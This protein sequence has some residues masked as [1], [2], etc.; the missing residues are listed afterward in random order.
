MYEPWNEK[1]DTV[2]FREYCPLLKLF[3]DES[4]ILT[5]TEATEQQHNSYSWS[6][7]HLR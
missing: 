2:F 1:S 7:F 3:S 6:S 4:T 5:Q